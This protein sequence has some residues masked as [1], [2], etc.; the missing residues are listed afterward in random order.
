MTSMTVPESQTI[1]SPDHRPEETFV[2]AGIPFLGG[3]AA[4]V[5]GA[6]IR[7][8]EMPRASH[9][10]SAWCG[11]IAHSAELTANAASPGH[12]AGCILLAAGVAAIAMS[13]LFAAQTH[14]AARAGVNR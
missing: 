9:L 11:P 4:A 6:S 5:T 10:A 1:D 14:L 7:S 3:L 13:I 8:C 2:K 12:C